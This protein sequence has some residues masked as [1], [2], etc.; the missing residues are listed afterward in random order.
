[1]SRIRY[2]KPASLAVFFKL[3]ALLS[4]ILCNFFEVYNEAQRAGLYAGWE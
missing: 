4:I 1:M 2:N 3:F